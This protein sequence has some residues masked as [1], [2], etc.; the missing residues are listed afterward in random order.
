MEESK[1]PYRHSV[2]QVE[3]TFETDI[4]SGLS[5][6]EAKNRLETYG[7]NI[8]EKKKT[9]SPW[10][11]LIRQFKD[12]IILI[13]F[14]ASIVS[15][16]IGDTVE[17]FAVL[18]VIILTTAFGFFTEYRA[19]KSVEALQGMITPSAKVRRDGELQEIE[20]S[21]LVPGDIVIVEE[22]D[23]VTADGRLTEADH[24]KVEESMLTGESEPV[25]KNT[26]TLES[27]K[28]PVADRTNMVHMGTTL[29]GGNGEF[30]VTG[31]GESTEMGK[32][33]EMLQ[34]TVDE[35]TPLEKQL[36]STGKFL[37]YVTFAI[38]FIVAIV[39]ILSGRPPL[40]MIKTAVALAVAAVPEGLPAVATITLAIGMRKM[41]KKNALVKTL[42]AVETLGSTTVIATDKTGTLTENQMTLDTFTLGGRTIKVSG[43]GYK[44][45][46]DFY[47]GET[48]IDPQ[49]DEGIR[50]FLEVSFLASNAV[51]SKDDETD[52]WSVIGDPTEGALVVAASKGGSVKSLNEKDTKRLDE[53]PFDPDEQF[54][55]VLTENKDQERLIALKGAPKAVLKRSKYHYAANGEIKELTEEDKK[56]YIK[57]NEDLAKK[58]LRVLA[59]AYKENPEKAFRE[60]AEE[61][62]VFLGLAGIF[63]PPRSDVEASIKDAQSAGIRLLMVTGDQPDTAASIA[64][65]LGIE[66]SDGNVVLGSELEN[67]S[68]EALAEKLKTH[69]IYARV[70][71]EHKLTILNALNKQDEITA[72]TGDGVN[73]APALKRADI[74]ISM[75]ARGTEVAKEASDMVLLDD[76]FN[77]IVSAV[78]EGRV[79][80][81]NIQKFIHYLLTINL[82]EIVLIFAAI[83]LGFPVPLTAIQILWLNMITG[84]FPAFSLAFETPEARTMTDPPRDPALPI[85]TDSYKWRIVFQ[86]ILIMVGP[87]LAYIYF[88]NS[89]AHTLEEAR[90]IGFMTLAIVHLLQVFNARRQNGLGFDG[91]MFKNPYLWGAA[92]LTIGLQLFAIYAPFMQSI[93]SAS[94]LGAIDW[95]F[96]VFFALIPII[97]LQAIAFIR[98]K[99]GR[100]YHE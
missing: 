89:D 48:K 70:S 29:T 59:L 2:S 11:V 68:S 69:R 31:T 22:G 39:G 34:E 55:A 90:T 4:K 16:A 72:M 51:L 57:Q 25:L 79:I 95:A 5:E 82:S 9:I 38:T 60:A 28:V 40:E 17:G 100:P 75:G 32:I 94:P 77:T 45:E 67:L 36:H 43:T 30:I 71:P 80:L 14:V 44:P 83:L 81:D 46:G 37:I 24:L 42:P 74:G 91:S 12:V 85:I 53:M 13:L 93:L 15:F 86:G 84:V 3:K 26:E 1:S 92:A 88:M 63:D 78:R 58:G 50:H 52:E 41:A 98:L 27:N 62:L 49:S 87:L 21:H 96:M 33:S 35:T 19:E 6:E 97:I 56:Y 23:R 20:A 65:K 47:D 64:H 73:D 54:M 18:G 7:R 66:G 10:E 76:S 8:L 61:E 99:A